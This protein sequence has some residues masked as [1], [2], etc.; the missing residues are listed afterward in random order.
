MPF[1][2]CRDVLDRVSEIV[3]GEAG[4]VARAR[5]HAPLA[6]CADCTLYFEQ[7]KAVRE[8]AG[9]VEPEDVPVDFDEVL[10]SILDKLDLD[11]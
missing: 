7:F 10:G 5:F 2:K 6:M 1:S 9:V 8:A 3:D 4:P 11:A